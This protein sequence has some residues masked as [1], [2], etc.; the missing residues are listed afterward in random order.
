MLASDLLKSI[1]NIFQSLF[2]LC[3]LPRYQSCCT[4]LLDEIGHTA[5]LKTSITSLANSIT[6][7]WRTES[8]TLGKNAWDHSTE[9]LRVPYYFYITFWA[10][11]IVNYKVLVHKMYIQKQHCHFPAPFHGNGTSEKW[12]QK[13]FLKYTAWGHFDLQ[14]FLLFKFLSKFRVAVSIMITMDSVC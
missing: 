4:M 13:Q 10:D 9:S 5:T 7:G 1:W 12:S 14:L 2:W 11:R 3:Q 8:I 6:F